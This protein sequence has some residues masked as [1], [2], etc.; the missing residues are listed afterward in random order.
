MKNRF[1]KKQ[2]FTIVEL[3]IVLAV[4]GILAAILI[5]SFTSIIGKANAK[6]A[7][8]DAKS[9]L[10]LFTAENLSV[11]DGRIADSIVIFVKK[12]KRYYLFGCKMNGNDAGVLMQSAGNPYNTDDLAELIN[13]YNCPNESIIGTEEESSYA[14]YLKA[15]STDSYEKSKLTFEEINQRFINLTD[16]LADRCDFPKAVKVFDGYLIGSVLDA[17][18]VQTGGTDLSDK[19]SGEA[20]NTPEYTLHFDADG[21][22]LFLSDGFTNGQAFDAGTNVTEIIVEAYAEKSNY[23]FC[24]WTDGTTVYDS[25][26]TGVVLLTKDITLTA[27]WAENKYNLSYELSDNEIVD[28]GSYSFGEAVILTGA[29]TVEGLYFDGWYCAHKDMKFGAGASY[30]MPNC[31]VV[32]TAVWAERFTI[33]FEKNDGIGDVPPAEM[34]NAGNE[35][36]LPA[37][38][39]KA[40]YTFEGWLCSYDNDIY[41]AGAIYTVEGNAVFT[42]VFNL[43]APA[44]YEIEFNLHDVFNDEVKTVKVKVSLNNGESLTIDNSNFSDYVAGY[45]PSANFSKTFTVSGSG[46]SPGTQSAEVIGF[47]DIGDKEFIKITTL[48]GLNKIDDNA[49]NMSKNYMLANDIDCAGGFTPLGW[50]NG[51]SVSITPFTG[52]FDGNGKKI[53]NFTANYGTGSANQ[54]NYVGLFAHNSG[55]IKNLQL[56]CGDAVL[57]L[58]YVGGIAAYNEG[59]IS[60]CAVQ[61]AHTISAQKD[62]GQNG[63]GFCGAIAGYNS[64]AGIISG[65]TSD[66]AQVFAYAHSGG[67]AGTNYGAIT[68]CIASSGVNSN[69]S[70]DASVSAPN[71]GILLYYAGG[72]AGSNYGTISDCRTQVNSYAITGTRW[73]GGVTGRNSANATVEGCIIIISNNQEISSRG[74]VGGAVG[75]NDQGIIEDTHVEM[76]SELERIVA[77]RNS[78]HESITGAFAGGIAGIN[79]LGTISK[80]SLFG[81]LGA[82][83]YVDASLSSSTKCFYV[84]GIAGRNTGTISESWSYRPYLNVRKYNE[85]GK[86]NFKESTA[87]CLQEVGGIAGQNASGGVIINCWTKTCTVSGYMNLGGLV[88][89]N[90]EGASIRY[91]WVLLQRCYVVSGLEMYCGDAYSK[92]SGAGSCL[93]VYTTSPDSLLFP[94]YTTGTFKGDPANAALYPGLS[95]SLWEPD[96]VG[97]MLKNNPLIWDR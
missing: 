84:G 2:A 71:N 30:E 59:E 57:G 72:I 65:C 43:I 3:I 49:A 79:H 6:S 70:I 60:N 52:V 74:I 35:I 34:Y 85:I 12:A 83:I 66:V 32:L 9:T 39:T 51:S 15:A 8:S 26:Y 61:S 31:D 77:A 54:Q 33:S 69:H 55:M 48:A 16:K 18:A 45:K 24:G 93:N 76:G 90:L 97:P 88:G 46:I 89:S 75:L 47:A 82:N 7:L 94:S 91:C 41:E 25:G 28:G 13:E 42:A 14:M 38:L 40:G 1:A 73:V 50:T 58:T 29:P 36:S 56:V 80:S 19:P 68:D 11:T 86:S 78:S 27:V 64:A 92:N 22:E 5:P 96:P 53:T 81:L 67:I 37:A 21:G 4:V 10:T 95:S 17:N 63:N 87:G 23:T 62:N 44:E 20:P